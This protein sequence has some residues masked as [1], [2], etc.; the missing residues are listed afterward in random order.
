MGERGCLAL[1]S[2]YGLVVAASTYRIGDPDDFTRAVE[3]VNTGRKPA[4]RVVRYTED[5][6]VRLGRIAPRLPAM[7]ADCDLCDGW[8]PDGDHGSSNVRSG[9][10]PG[11]ATDGK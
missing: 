4:D 2:R 3:F 11:G 8:H 1:V 6:P 7:T 9:A 5:E 10:T